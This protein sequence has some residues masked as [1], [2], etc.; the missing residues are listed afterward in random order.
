VDEVRA[1][2]LGCIDLQLAGGEV[3]HPLQHPVVHLGA[4]AAVSALLAFVRQHGFDPVLDASD[5]VG[6]GDLCERVAVVT[7]AELD[8]GAVVVDRLDPQALHRAIAHQRQLDL[9][10]PIGAVVVAVGHVVDPVLDVF[11]RTPGEVR[12]HSGDRRDL[13]REQLGSEA[14][15]GRVRLHVQSIRRDLQRSREHEQVAGEAQRVGVDREHP[16]AHVEARDRADRL[17]WLP[18]RAVPAQ[19]VGDD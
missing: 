9:V 15:A 14:A 1:A 4:E 3:D 10:D 11:D 8:V 19:A 2:D 5:S 13:G 6:T 18:A 16:G 7:D 17:E 12:E